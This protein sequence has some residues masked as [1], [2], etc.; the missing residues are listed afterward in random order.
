MSEK[1]NRLP[2]I[3]RNYLETVLNVKASRNERETAVLMLENIIETCQ[4]AVS[5]YKSGRRQ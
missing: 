3:I 2:P 5:Y 4:K 1:I